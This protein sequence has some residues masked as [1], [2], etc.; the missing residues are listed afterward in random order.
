MALERNDVA[1]TAA[2]TADFRTDLGIRSVPYLGTALTSHKYTGSNLAFDLALAADGG[3]TVPAW[4]TVPSDA[5]GVELWGS[6]SAAADGIAFAPRS[7]VLAN[8]GVLA[9]N[10][11]TNKGASGSTAVVHVLAGAHITIPFATQGAV[12]AGW[13]VA[14]L[15]TAGIKL[16]G[17]YI[18][19]A[20]NLPYKIGGT[21]EFRLV[22]AGGQQLLPVATT[23]KFPVGYV[24]CVMQ[25]IGAGV[26]F[27]LDGSTTGAAVGDILAPGIYYVDET[28][29]GVS[30][31]AMKIWL[32]ASTF[33]VGHS[34]IAA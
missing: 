14:L 2:E 24:G 11:A 4:P 5:T 30:L 29:H 34:L 23:A 15:E 10:T 20:A 1:F 6:T 32:P 31:A 27:T 21:E 7:A 28:R 12:P 33:V 25:V 26:R 17:R 9:T 8:T 19:A 22:G 3:P 18:S 13:R 16:Q